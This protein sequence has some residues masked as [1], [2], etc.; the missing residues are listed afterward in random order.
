[1]DILSAMTPPAAITIGANHPPVESRAKFTEAAY[2]AYE[3]KTTH[4]NPA[5]Q[6][7]RE[8]MAFDD[9]G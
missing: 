1:M 9:T 6:Q 8:C 2:V 5:A 4:I 7:F 3:A